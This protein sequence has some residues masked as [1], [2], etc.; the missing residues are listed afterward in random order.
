MYF[1]NSSF[2]VRVLSLLLLMEVLLRLMWPL[3]RRM[4]GGTT[5]PLIA[6]A[7]ASSASAH[8]GAFAFNMDYSPSAAYW[9]YGSAKKYRS[10][11]L[12]IDLF[13]FILMSYKYMYRL[14]QLS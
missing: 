2:L 1:I 5:V 9:A 4:R 13:S 11:V 7:G 6:G 12:S 3:F 10:M 8:G 14:S